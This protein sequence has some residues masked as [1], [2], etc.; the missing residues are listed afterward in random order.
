[1]DL[2]SQSCASLLQ[3]ALTGALDNKFITSEECKCLTSISLKEFEAASGIDPQSCGFNRYFS[4]TVADD[5][6][7]CCL[8]KFGEECSE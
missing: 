3:D 6:A 8:L 1:M 7:Y 2:I 4:R 5:V